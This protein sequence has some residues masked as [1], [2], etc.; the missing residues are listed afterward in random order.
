[1]KLRKRKPSQ[2]YE[3]VLGA[4]CCRGQGLCLPRVKCFIGL[5]NMG[6]LLILEMEPIAK[7]NAEEAVAGV[8][9][10]F[11]LVNLCQAEKVAG[12]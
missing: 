10:V 3:Q 1:M 12:I 11:G 7:R 5:C 2:T 9:W 6:T 8:V 4:N